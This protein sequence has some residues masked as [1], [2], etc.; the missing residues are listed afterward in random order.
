MLCVVF[1]LLPGTLTS[2]VECWPSV[3]LAE[4]RYS[5]DH[6]GSE[7][8][9]LARLKEHEQELLTKYWKPSFQQQL[10]AEVEKFQ[11]LGKIL[12]EYV[13]FCL[14]LLAW[15]LGHKLGA[16]RSLHPSQLSAVCEH[17][18]FGATIQSAFMMVETNKPNPRTANWIGSNTKVPPTAGNDQSWP[19]YREDLKRWV[20]F[21]ELPD[22]KLAPADGAKGFSE[23]PHFLEKYRTVDLANLKTVDGFKYLID[24]FNKR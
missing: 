12:E 23:N 6:R 1:W 8:R 5:S 18:I 10:V 13:L 24:E 22:E 17:F 19:S 9:G 11:V 16:E 2:L 4:T 20:D 21:A 15:R 14:F 7:P 3:D